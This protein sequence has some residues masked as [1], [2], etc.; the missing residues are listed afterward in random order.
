MGGAVTQTVSI[1]VIAAELTG[2]PHLALPIGLAV[3]TAVFL[4]R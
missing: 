3:C 2:Q 1:A 4:S